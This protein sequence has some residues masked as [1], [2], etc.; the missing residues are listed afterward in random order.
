MAFNFLKEHSIFNPGNLLKYYFKII[1][2]SPEQITPR[3]VFVYIRMCEVSIS[4]Y[5]YKQMQAC[6]C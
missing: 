5:V 3:Y 1:K 6:A 4:V 2:K